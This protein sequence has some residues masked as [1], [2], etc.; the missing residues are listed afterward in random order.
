MKVDFVFGTRPEAIKMA[1][2]ILTLKADDFFDV[3]VISTGQHRQMLNHVLNWFHITCDADLNVMVENQSL[4]SLSANLILAL[5]TFYKEKG[6]PD[7][8]VVQGDTS[9]A[10]LASLVAFYK[11]CKVAHIEAGLRTNDKYSPFPEEINRSLLSKLADIHFAPTESSKANLLGEGIND[12]KIFVVGNTVIDSLIY[13]SNQIEALDLFPKELE[14]FYSGKYQDKRI[15]L[16]TGHRRESFGEAFRQICF[17]IKELAEKFSD[18][19]FIYPVHLNPQ[20]R[21]PVFELLG[22]NCTKNILL[23]DP[24][25]YEDFVSLLK[26]AYIVLTDSG[27]I[28]EEAPSIGKPVLVMRNNTERPEAVSHGVAKLVGTDKDSIVQAA[29]LLLDNADHY[30]SMARSENPYGDGQTSSRIL[31]ILKDGYDR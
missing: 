22:S 11:K 9:T 28:Q 21:R 7:W 25:N 16:I 23:V 10:F 3:R 18:V 15:V 2:P 1:L 29:S 26:R 20:V 24:L 5:D 30:R 27:G 17:A 13:S 14:R 6:V 8:I 12:G 31:N 19:Y 4:E